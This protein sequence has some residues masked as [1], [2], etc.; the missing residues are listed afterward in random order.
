MITK[1]YIIK[2][3]RLKWKE[4]SGDIGDYNAIIRYFNETPLFNKNHDSV[5]WAAVAYDYIFGF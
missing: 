3:L 5:F 4:N 1:S 2:V